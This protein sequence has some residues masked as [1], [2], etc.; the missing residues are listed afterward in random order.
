V[1]R[2]WCAA[3]EAIKI[4]SMAAR[5]GEADAIVADGGEAMISVPYFTRDVI[6]GV[7][8]ATL[9]AFR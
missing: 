4:S 6:Y 5:V 2:A 8:V 3:M 9:K 1:N 7:T